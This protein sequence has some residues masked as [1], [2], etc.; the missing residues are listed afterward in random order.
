MSELY[1]STGVIRYDPRHTKTRHDDW[2]MIVE[3]GRGLVL[4]YKW[5]LDRD[6][7]K[8][9]PSDHLFDVDTRYPVIQ[10][11][12]KV[13]ESAW[14]A[15]ISVVRGEKPRN[16]DAWRKY[17]GKRIKFQYSP[18]VQTNGAHYWL[19]VISDDLDD[20]RQ[21]L[22]LTKVA[23]S[24]RPGN[25]ERYRDHRGQMIRR[26]AQFHLTIGKDVDEHPRDRKRWR[27]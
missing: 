11:G 13:S 22:G 4:T 21:E 25:P 27:K 2:W 17:E 14:K 3:C 20:I 16:P 9:V 5:L 10:R 12:V 19:P 15:H 24:Y 1:T 6:G 18:M 26:P 8:I 23:R 7:T